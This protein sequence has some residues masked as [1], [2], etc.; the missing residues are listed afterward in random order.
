MWEHLRVLA[1][2]CTEQL[3][4]EIESNRKIVAVGIDGEEIQ[5]VFLDTDHWTEEGLAG[6]EAQLRREAEDFR[7]ADCPLDMQGLEDWLTKRSKAYHD[8]I[9][10]LCRKAR[11]AAL[12]SQIR[13]E[14]GEELCEAFRTQGFVL[15]GA[16]EPVFE[17]LDERK[18]LLMDFVS[19]DRTH[20][21]VR[22]VPD[23]EHF[24]NSL[25][26][27]S[28]DAEKLPESQLRARQKDINALLTRS[29]QLDIAPD[30]EKKNADPAVRQAF[31]EARSKLAPHGMM[32]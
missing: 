10:G 28:Y 25:E 6:L 27:H 1:R 12:L 29:L 18:A 3:L 15:D 16:S 26:I 7:S 21:A 9:G 8:E 24:R 22:I 17:E 23:P 4:D 14:M 31:Q 11:L 2:A 32:H 20:I 13:S 30:H 19:R 5:G